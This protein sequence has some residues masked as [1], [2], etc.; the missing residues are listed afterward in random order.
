[1]G[2]ILGIAAIVGVGSYFLTRV[3]YAG[4]KSATSR[5]GKEFKTPYSNV[6]FYFR[7][8]NTK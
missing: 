6:E 3:V 1:V 4:Y 2:Q 7:D 5:V 8:L